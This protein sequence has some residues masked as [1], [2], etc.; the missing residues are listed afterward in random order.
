MVQIPLILFILSQT[1]LPQRRQICFWS[2]I[3]NI[4]G[5]KLWIENTQSVVCFT[6]SAYFNF[7]EWYITFYVFLTP[8]LVCSCLPTTLTHK[9]AWW[10]DRAVVLAAVTLGLRAVWMKGCSRC[11]PTTV[12]AQHEVPSQGKQQEPCQRSCIPGQLY[13]FYFLPRK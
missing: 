3:L 12:C 1:F 4:S 5:P 8:L 13:F 7:S 10:R 6:E 11:R 2:Q 9:P